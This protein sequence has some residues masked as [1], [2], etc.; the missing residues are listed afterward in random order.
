MRS[1]WRVSSVAVVALA[2]LAGTGVV[3]QGARATTPPG[4]VSQAGAPHPNRSHTPE[5]AADVVAVKYRNGAAGTDA[6][7]ATGYSRV[8]TPRGRAVATAHSLET[9][10]D[11]AEVAP[12]FTRRIS[13]L[14]NDQFYGYEPYLGPLHMPEAWG[15]TKG[16]GTVI[17]VLDT[18]VN[19]VPDLAGRVLPGIDIVNSD[20]N[21]AD[22][23]GHG[24]MVAGVAAATIGNA[25]GIAGVAGDAKILPVKVLDATGAG[26]DPDIAA[27]ITWATDHGANVI[28]LSLG[29]Y[30]DSP[31][32]DS[33][34]AYAAA[35]NV[36]VVAAAGNDATNEPSYPA[37]TPSVVAVSATDKNGRLAF[38]SNYGDYIDV[39][40]PGFNVIGPDYA[41]SNQY[42]VESGTSF[43]SPM[44]AGV[45]A[46]VHTAKPSLTAAQIADAISNTASDAGPDGRDQYFGAGVVNAWAALGGPIV[47]PVVSAPAGDANEPN[48]TP[49]HAMP[50][51]AP[52]T[53]SGT[54]GVEGDTD[55]FAFDPLAS[56]TLTLTVS[57]P[58]PNDLDAR[59]LDVVA[60]AYNSDLQPLAQADQNGDPGSG[61]TLTL[62]TTAG[63]RVYV[64]VRNWLPSASNGAY[65][66]S[67]SLAPTTVPSLPTPPPLGVRLASPDNNGPATAGQQAVLR[68]TTAVSPSTLSAITFVRADTG[69]AVAATVTQTAS[70]TATVVPNASLVAAPYAVRIDGVD[71]TRFTVGRPTYAPFASAPSFVSALYSDLLFHPADAALSNWLGNLVQTYALDPATFTDAYLGTPEFL[72]TVSPITRLYLAYFHNVPAY[73]GM[74]GW[75]AAYRTGTRLGTVSQWFWDASGAQSTY[76]GLSNAAFI[77]KAFR[78][79]LLRAPNSAESTAWVNLLNSG[80]SRAD[81]MSILSQ[82]PEYAARVRSTVELSAVYAG[83]L[84]RAP[85][86][87]ELFGWLAALDAG[88][89]RLSLVTDIF[90]S[91]EY[92]ARFGPV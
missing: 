2:A 59:A 49:D 70:D 48:D 85:S 80:Y 33:A 16:T 15:T 62:A 58:A 5:P 11:V 31:V 56:G 65:T 40:A 17:A 20:S 53:A 61:E 21:P 45:A 12:V 82:L 42:D 36:V 75:T 78:A 64:R 37:A 92:A 3:A 9:D 19:A 69:A 90:R 10:A 13:A 83:M 4:R 38:F 89:T 81:A 72:N 8:R 51:V 76:G 79:V 22:D 57:A 88:R 54:I 91:R 35:H 14:P 32:L 41:V 60:D 23:N 1:C 87:P 67:T 63:Q 84:R 71:A 27:G 7:G 29:G 39:A 86:A 52:A 18:G 26:D 46:L 6:I 30:G 68:F 73:N 66:V 55:W 50:L 34:L 44:V 74:L 24:T 47:D 43:S 25:V 28:N 77:D